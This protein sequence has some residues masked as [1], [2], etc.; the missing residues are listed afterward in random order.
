MAAKGI[1]GF[2]VLAASWGKRAPLGWDVTDPEPVA[3]T[4]AFLLSDWSNG[5]TAEIIHVDGG[6]H[7]IG[8]ELVPGD[9]KPPQSGAAV[10]GPHEG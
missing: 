4:I 6:Y 2:D 3:R 1:P 8:A 5:I 10:E 9:Q 7:A